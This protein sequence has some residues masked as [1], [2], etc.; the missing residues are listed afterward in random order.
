MNGWY[1]NIDYLDIKDPD[2]DITN[3]FENTMVLANLINAAAIKCVMCHINY[4]LS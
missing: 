4:D 3:C 2:I 1:Y